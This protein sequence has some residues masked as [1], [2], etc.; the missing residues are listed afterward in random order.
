M[1]INKFVA[2]QLGHPTELFAGLAGSIW[3]KRNAELNERVMDLLEPQAG[4]RVL[5]IGF[6]GGYLL[7]RMLTIVVDGTLA[8]VD[9]SPAMAR[10]AEKRFQKMPNG[11]R[12]R[13][14]CAAAEDLPFADESFTKVCSVNS[15]FYWQDAEKGVREMRRVLAS[16]GRAVLCFTCKSSIETQRFARHL[17][18]FDNEEVIQLVSNAGFKD[19]EPH[20][21]SDPY[22][23]FLCVRASRS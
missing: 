21:F 22:R 9:V 5:D 2:V 10:R 3:N 1:A 12:A 8:G 20:V 16:E 15:I 13:F 14:T 23:Q 4:D 17:R 11:K 19:I 6:G 18:L 7:G